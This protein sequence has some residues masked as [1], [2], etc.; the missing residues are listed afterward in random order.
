[1][2]REGEVQV[3]LLL[4]RTL[5]NGSAGGPREKGRARVTEGELRAL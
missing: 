5:G 3:F 2:W 4:G 1:M